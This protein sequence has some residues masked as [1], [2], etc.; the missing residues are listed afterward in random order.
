[1]SCVVLQWTAVTTCYHS[2]PH[3][4]FFFAH[5]LFTSQYIYCCTQEIR[6]TFGNGRI[7]T[8]SCALKGEKKVHLCLTDVKLSTLLIL[9]SGFL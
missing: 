5:D 6:T 3:S 1:M 8:Q 7:L 4:R 9:L 2:L